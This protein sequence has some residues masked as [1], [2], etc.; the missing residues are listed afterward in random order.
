MENKNLTLENLKATVLEAFEEMD[1]YDASDTIQVTET[2][3]D[4]KV[5]YCANRFTNQEEK[6]PLSLFKGKH[7]TRY[8]FRIRKEP[9]GVCL[10]KRSTR[11]QRKW[12]GNSDG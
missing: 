4:F 12:I 9:E 8:I 11:V 2:D 7:L 6:D 10:S 1:M 5:E 3:Y